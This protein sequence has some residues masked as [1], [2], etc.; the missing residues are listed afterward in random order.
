MVKIF[1][2]ILA[3][4]ILTGGGYF[5][6]A[7]VFGKHHKIG[8]EI[9][10]AFVESQKKLEDYPKEVLGDAKDNINKVYQNSLE[11]FYDQAQSVVNNV[12]QKDNAQQDVSISMAYDNANGQPYIVDLAKG[13]KIQISLKKNSKYYLQFQNVP[14]DS[15]LYIGESK[16]KLEAS[17]NIELS[18]SNT[19]TYQLNVNSCSANNKDLGQI[20]VE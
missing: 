18:F 3:V 9:T 8:S 6:W 19:G 2:S 10:N 17:K 7:N 16:Y 5:V 11:E 12:F 13:S 14:T 15:C 4:V 1:L 20:V